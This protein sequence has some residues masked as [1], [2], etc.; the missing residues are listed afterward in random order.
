MK[1]LL[2]ILTT[3][4]ILTVVT[5]PSVS[6]LDLDD[7]NSAKSGLYKIRGTKLLCHRVAKAR[8]KFFKEKKNSEGGVEF[9]KISKRRLKKKNTLRRLKRRC[10]RAEESLFDPI[11]DP[12]DDPANNSPGDEPAPADPQDDPELPAGFSEVVASITAQSTAGLSEVALEFEQGQFDEDEK[13]WTLTESVELTATSGAL[14]GVLEDFSLTLNS[15]NVK[16]V[17]MSYKVVAGEAETRFEITPTA[18]SFEA[19][20]NPGARAS[21]WMSLND[22][23]QDGAEVRLDMDVPYTGKGIYLATFNGSQLFY[24]ILGSISCSGCA[25]AG[26][27]GHSGSCSTLVSATVTE[28]GSPSVFFLSAF[29]GVEGSGN[30]YLRPEC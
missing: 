29:D 14:V 4:A 12:S 8:I 10:K 5:V 11:E 30:F 18:L 17:K 19:M 21:F 24:P 3:I 23:F 6:A 2:T 7:S 1:Y 26:A 16:Q 27:G 28:I 20:E 25:H 13:T 9:T 22:T 15:Y